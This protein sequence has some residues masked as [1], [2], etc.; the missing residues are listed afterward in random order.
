LLAE[1]LEKKRGRRRRRGAAG[2]GEEEEGPPVER[3]KRSGR[4]R[5]LGMEPAEKTRWE[6]RAVPSLRREHERQIRLF[7]CN[8]GPVG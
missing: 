2:K 6:E 8:S 3:K 4:R 5:G 7:R 1:L